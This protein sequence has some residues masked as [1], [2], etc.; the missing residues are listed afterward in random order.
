MS[1]AD[2]R[3]ASRAR[4]TAAVHRHAAVSERRVAAAVRSRVPPPLF[5]LTAVSAG[6]RHRAVSSLKP[7]AVPHS[8][9]PRRHVLCVVL[10]RLTPPLP[11]C[12][13]LCTIGAEQRRHADKHRRRGRLSVRVEHR[14]SERVAGHSPASMKSSCHRVCKPPSSVH[15]AP[16]SVRAARAA[17]RRAARS[18]AARPDS[19]GP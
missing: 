7:T 6:K 13:P 9:P 8:L 11:V 1:D 4:P 18:W 15:A 16:P 19:R 2:R 12:R 14:R 5:E 3:L 10:S 17:P